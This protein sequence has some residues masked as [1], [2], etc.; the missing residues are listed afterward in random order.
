MTE[1]ERKFLVDKQALGVILDN[2]PQCYD[3]RQAY[4]SD[5]PAVRV[6]VIDNKRAELTIKKRVNDTSS[7]EIN[8]DISVD[9][10]KGVIEEICDDKVIHKTRHLYNGW[11]ID[12][13]REHFDGLV[14]AEFEG[15]V[16][17]VENLIVPPWCSKEV[18]TDPK[19]KNEQMFNELNS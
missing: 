6:R 4:V 5:D 9:E 17:E 15:S 14:V 16:D 13:F 1:T 19:Y 7:K 12:V 3:I 10:A 18:T 2:S 11:E 8:V